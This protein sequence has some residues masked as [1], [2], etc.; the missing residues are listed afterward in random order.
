MH[1]CNILCDI[2]FSSKEQIH[3]PDFH[4]I[5]KQNSCAAGLNLVGDLSPIVFAPVL[6]C[7]NPQISQF[8]LFGETIASV[9]LL[10]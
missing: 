8:I 3:L 6:L 10:A 4:H 2:S 7:T 1:Y 5:L 9:S